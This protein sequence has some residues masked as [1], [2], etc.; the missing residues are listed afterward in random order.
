MEIKMLD[1]RHFDVFWGQGWTNWAR[2]QNNNGFLKQ[3]KGIEIP[4]IVFAQ[5]IAKFSKKEA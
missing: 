4:K 1:E 3:I 5:L 2:I